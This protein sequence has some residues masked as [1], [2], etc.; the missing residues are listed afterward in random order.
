MCSLGSQ[1]PHETG[2]ISKFELIPSLQESAFCGPERESCVE[3]QTLRDKSC[4]V[5]CT[6]LYADIAD[7]SLEQTTQV[8]IEGNCDVLS[9]IFL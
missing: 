8:L 6:G 4:L 7:D 3:N 1:D 5:P 2:D 9:L